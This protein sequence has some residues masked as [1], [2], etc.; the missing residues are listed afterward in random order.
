MLCKGIGV[1]FVVSPP[2]GPV[3]TL[4]PWVGVIPPDLHGFYNWVFDALGLLNDVSK[5]VVADRR[6]AGLRRWATWLWEDIGAW[7]Y[8]WLRPDFVPPSPNLVLEDPVA[9]TS[10]ILVEPH[11]IDGEFRKAWMPFFCRSG[12]PVVTVDQ[13]F[14]SPGS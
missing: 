8:V 7:P 2:C 10:R 1:R 3:C 9:Q 5:Q 11:L 13:S 6:E 14:P 4:E 12:H